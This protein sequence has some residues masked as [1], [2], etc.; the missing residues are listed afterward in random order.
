[1]YVR[2]FLGENTTD[3]KEGC[4]SIKMTG[5]DTGRQKRHKLCSNEVERFIQTKRKSYP[6]DE[7]YHSIIL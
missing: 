7:F 6:L 1:M 5:K 2:V 4:Q 3:S